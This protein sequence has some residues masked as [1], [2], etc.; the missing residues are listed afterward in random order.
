M[1]SQAPTTSRLGAESQRCLLFLTND[2]NVYLVTCEHHVRSQC[3][4]LF[5]RRSCCKKSPQTE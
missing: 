2:T 4:V 3:S 5:V 1:L